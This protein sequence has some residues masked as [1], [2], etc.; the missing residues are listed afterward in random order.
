ED[1]RRYANQTREI[2]IFRVLAYYALITAVGAALLYFFPIVREAFVAPLGDRSLA[3]ID[4][5]VDP[6]VSDAFTSPGG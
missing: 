6:S 1:R 5:P 2:P 4:N 3:T